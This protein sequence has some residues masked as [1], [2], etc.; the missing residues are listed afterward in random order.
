MK[1]IHDKVL[2]I[3]ETKPITRD[4]DKH[5]ITAFAFFYARESYRDGRVDL[6]HESLPSFESI[7]RARRKI[8]ESG[9]FPATVKVKEARDDRE[10]EIR[11]AYATGQL[12]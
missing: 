7:T 1:K 2:H 10:A 4:S 11:Y 8:Q 5:L 12:F 9:L 3:L 6:L